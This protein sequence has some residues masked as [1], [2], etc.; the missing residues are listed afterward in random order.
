MTNTIL[1]K[2]YKL[3]S[4]TL[5]EFDVLYLYNNQD[6]AVLMNKIDK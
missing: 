3:K 6:S 5:P 1:N 2:K 4:L